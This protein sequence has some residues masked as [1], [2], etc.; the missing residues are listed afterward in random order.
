MAEVKSGRRPYEGTE[1][2][3]EKT[4]QEVVKLLGKHFA[5]EKASWA[6]P[7]VAKKVAGAFEIETKERT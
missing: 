7:L 1:V 4:Q 3:Y 6:V 2:A 5:V